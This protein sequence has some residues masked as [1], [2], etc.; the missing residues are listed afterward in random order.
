MDG[1]FSSLINPDQFRRGCFAQ[2]KDMKAMDPM[3][4]LGV[5]LTCHFAGNHPRSH[6]YGEFLGLAKAVWL[7]HLLAFSLDP[8]PS[9]YEANCGA[10]FHSQYM[11]SVVM[12]LDGLVP[13]G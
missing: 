6:F 13:A 4:L 7:L 2:F 1:S 12:F 10:E 9:H 8:S 11:E 3:E 5:L